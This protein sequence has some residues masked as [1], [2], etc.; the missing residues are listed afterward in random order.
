[1][2]KPRRPFGRGAS[3]VLRAR[4]R[5]RWGHPPT[6]SSAYLATMR[7]YYLC[8]VLRSIEVTVFRPINA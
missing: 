8:A 5:W 1:V 7:S 4:P 2:T 3:V 6:R